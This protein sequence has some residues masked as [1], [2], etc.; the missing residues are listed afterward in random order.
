MADEDLIAEQ[1]ALREFF[2]SN[3]FGSSPRDLLFKAIVKQAL[4]GAPWREICGSLMQKQNIKM[5]EVEGVLRKIR[6][7]DVTQTEDAGASLGP[8]KEGQEVSKQEL[9]LPGE[10][11]EEHT[12]RAHLLEVIVTQALAGVRW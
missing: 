9:R 11:G 8:T 6:Q 5:E 7:S 1:A 4:A 2:D 10:L 12:N 3:G